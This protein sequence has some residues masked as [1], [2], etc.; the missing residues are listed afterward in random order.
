M[1]SAAGTIGSSREVRYYFCDRFYHYI[2]VG[3]IVACYAQDLVGKLIHYCSICWIFKYLVQYP[4]FFSRIFVN[5]V[6][7]VSPECEVATSTISKKKEK[8]SECCCVQDGPSVLQKH[9]CWE[10]SRHLLQSSDALHI[11]RVW[12]K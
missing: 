12:Y 5:A 8:R 2:V 1:S 11:P 3:C 6:T 4:I 9:G 10:S 7:R